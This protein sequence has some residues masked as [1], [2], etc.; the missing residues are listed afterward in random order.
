MA[1]ALCSRAC[2]KDAGEVGSSPELPALAL[3]GTEEV[4]CSH[5]HS[6]KSV[7]S[8]TQYMKH[9]AMINCVATMHLLL[10]D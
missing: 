5:N 1:S 10:L 3:P 8:N 6:Q 4:P 7:R 9:A 2:E